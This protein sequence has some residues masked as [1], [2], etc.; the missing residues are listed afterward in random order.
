MPTTTRVRSASL[1]VLLLLASGCSATT[2][3]DT[4]PVVTAGSSRRAS[5]KE[6][7]APAVP[8][9]RVV[10]R[11]G[12]VYARE[13]DREWPIA[14]VGQDEMLWAPDGM[15]FAYLR[16]EKATPTSQP[17]ASLETTTPAKS[18]PPG[19]KKGKDKT[20]VFHIVI[21]NIRGDSVN[22]FPVYRPGRPSALDWINN[23]TL[24]YIAPPDKSGD[25]YVLHS[26]STS[27]ILHV[28]RGSG[29][30]WSPGRKQLAYV[31]NPRH[32]HLVKVE[33][34]VVWPRGGTVPARPPK[35]HSGRRTRRIKGDLVWSPDGDGL[36]FLVTGGKHPRLVVLLVVDNEQGDL[37]WPL[38]NTALLPG[39]RLFWGDSK[40]VIGESMLK[41]RFAASWR[42]MR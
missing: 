42:R 18:S 34:A 16:Q 35:R 25:A 24:G 19:R 20:P 41:P 12:K 37:T 7:P 30:I 28:Y 8:T 26:V 29:F 39:N 32:D 31:A 5:T 9:V 36:A 14:E 13:G 15:R 4:P 2:G 23:D 11:D 22:E 33:N 17:T 38:P 40:V 21:R 3:A 10:F 1:L 27:E 6:A